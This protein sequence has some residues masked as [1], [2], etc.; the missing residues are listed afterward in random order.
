MKVTYTRRH[1]RTGKRAKA[2]LSM[3]AANCTGYRAT[4]IELGNRDIIGL[5]N[6]AARDK[7]RAIS[8]ILQLAGRLP[9][10][11]MKS[12]L[13]AIKDSER[14]VTGRK[15]G[16]P[17]MARTKPFHTGGK[18]TIESTPMMGVQS[19][20]FLTPK[21]KHVLDSKMLWPNKIETRVE[22]DPED[23]KP[24]DKVEVQMEGIWPHTKVKKV[25]K[26]TEVD[27][28]AVEKR[29]MA[30]MAS[31]TGLNAKMLRHTKGWPEIEAR[32]LKETQAKLHEACA[33]YLDYWVLFNLDKAMAYQL[34]Y[35]GFEPAQERLDEE[36]CAEV[37]AAIKQAEGVWDE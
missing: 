23:V 15:P 16:S 9:D 12:T 34:S 36:G 11:K 33:A 2:K 30:H 4:K 27:Y 32:T 17:S 20:P 28:S 3:C 29:V 21:E 22:I 14:T 24:G 8:M 31:A 7:D 35:R 1:P 18:V 6:I 13:S 37:M 26:L 25:T 10:K 5:A 19:A